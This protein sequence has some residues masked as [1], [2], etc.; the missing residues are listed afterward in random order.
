MKLYIAG[1]MTGLPEYNLPAFAEAAQKLEN[2]GYDVT[3]PGRHGVNP[4]YTWA[5]YLRRGVAELLQ[6]NGV[7]LLPGWQSSNGAQL[8]TYVARALDMPV[9]PLN[10]WVTAAVLFREG[11]H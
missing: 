2:Y 5:D 6:C 8:E 9:H 4:D 3:N 1:P 11:V 10:E 7:A